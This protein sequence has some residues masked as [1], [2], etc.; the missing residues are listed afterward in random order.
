MTFNVHQLLHLCTSVK[1]MGPL[2]AFSMFNFESGNGQLLKNINS[3]KGVLQQVVERVIMAQEL[4]HLLATDVI[5]LDVRD[6]CC[7]ML[8]YGHLKH[9]AYVGG[10]C[11][12]GNSKSARQFTEEER[13]A[14]DDVFG[15]CPDTA[16]EYCRVVLE[17]QILNSVHYKRAMK[18]DSSVVLTKSGEFGVIQRIIALNMNGREQCVALLSML[19]SKQEPSPFPKHIMEISHTQSDVAVLQLDEIGG[20]VLK[21]NIGEASY[22]AVLPN[23]VEHD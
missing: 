18:S 8:G 14:L 15:F 16:M 9:A 20:V 19:V 11:L 2:W 3:P 17:G 7:R 12:L 5:P 21:M 23:T 1:K 6:R 10:S 4:D 13:A 22:I